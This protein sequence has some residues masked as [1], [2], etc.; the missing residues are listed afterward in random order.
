MVTAA[1]GVVVLLLALLLLELLLLELLLLGLLLA[2][3]LMEAPPLPPPQAVKAK[4]QTEA[5]RRKALR[6]V[7]MKIPNHTF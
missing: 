5:V 7:S 3:V 2:L 1:G 6:D 4:R